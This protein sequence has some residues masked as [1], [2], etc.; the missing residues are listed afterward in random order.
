MVPE[1]FN[2]MHNLH[3][4]GNHVHNIWIYL[5][6]NKKNTKL[7]QRDC[8]VANRLKERKTKTEN[9]LKVSCD[10]PAAQV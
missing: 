6:S 9:W 4:F 10:N 7:I 8:T 5:K 3:G 1:K 2:N